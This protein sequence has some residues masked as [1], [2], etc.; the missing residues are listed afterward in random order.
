MI[1]KSK[2][3]IRVLTILIGAVVCCMLAYKFIADYWQ[4]ILITAGMIV[5][6]LIIARA[7]DY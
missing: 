1:E 2:A 6:L 4:E 3:V 5:V 7:F